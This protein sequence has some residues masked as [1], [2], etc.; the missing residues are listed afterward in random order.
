MERLH[1]LL[2]LLPVF[3]WPWL[4]LALPLPWLMRWWPQPAPR[5]QA[6]RVGW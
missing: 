6:L 2:S 5:V 4:W 3:A 1:E